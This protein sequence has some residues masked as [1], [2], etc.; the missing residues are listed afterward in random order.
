MSKVKRVST[1]P[2]KQKGTWTIQQYELH[3]TEYTVEADSLND[4]LEK[5]NEGEA[6]MGTSDYIEVASKY[7]DDG[8]REVRGPDG[9]MWTGFTGKLKKE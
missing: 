6:D 9:T 4:A 8:V 7:G 1:N 3:F 2:E 5:L